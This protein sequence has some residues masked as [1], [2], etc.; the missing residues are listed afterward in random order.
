MPD[1]FSDWPE[2]APKKRLA[3]DGLVSSRIEPNV[4]IWRKTKRVTHWQ[5]K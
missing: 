2:G 3:R 1:P 4:A 5:V